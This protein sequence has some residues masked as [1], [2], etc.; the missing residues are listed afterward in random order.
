[1]LSDNRALEYSDQLSSTLRSDAQLH[2]PHKKNIFEHLNITENK[3]HHEHAT[4]INGIQDNFQNQNVINTTNLRNQKSEHFHIAHANKRYQTPSSA[5]NNSHLSISDEKF[6]ETTKHENKSQQNFSM[7]GYQSVDQRN[8][9][10]TVL[11]IHPSR[12]VF[13]QLESFNENVSSNQN[14]Q[15]LSVLHED[16]RPIKNEEDIG[17]QAQL[18]HFIQKVFF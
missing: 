2:S 5:K 4:P 3:N 17:R 7:R 10:E 8:L 14:G 16:L 11:D 12:D 9:H 1:M 6:D 13:N 15:P 18:T